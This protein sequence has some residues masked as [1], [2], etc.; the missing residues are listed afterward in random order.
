MKTLAA[1]TLM[2]LAA[3]SAAADVQ[4]L[5]HV[6]VGGGYITTLNVTSLVPDQADWIVI[7]FYKENGSRWTVPSNLGNFDRLDLW[8]G[9]LQTQVV[10]LS[11]QSGVIESGWAMLV[12]PGPVALAAAYSA[13]VDSAPV[14][15]AGVLPAQA[16]VLN[17]LPV[18]IDAGAGRDTGVALVN[19]STTGG[20]ATFELVDAD[21][22]TVDTRTVAVPAKGKF[23]GLLSG[24]ALFP[25]VTALEGFL[26][27]TA[28]Q[29][30]AAAALRTEGAL[31]SALP[32]VHDILPWRNSHTIYVNPLLGSDHFNTGTLLSPYKTIRK[33]QS[34]SDR[35]WTI[36]L[37]PGLYS[38]ASGESFPV[39][40]GFCVQLRGADTRSV[41]ILGGGTTEIFTENCAVAGEYKGMISG[42]TIINPA[43]HGIF[44]NTSISVNGCR[45]IH[46]GG[47]GIE[48]VDGMP[49]ISDTT[50]TGNAVG[51]HVALGADPDLG[52]GLNF[53]TGGNFMAGN[54]QCDLFFE[55]ESVI[56]IRFNSWDHA[57]PTRGTVCTGGVDIAATLLPFIDY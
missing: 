11:S 1:L 7:H 20:D 12:S 37:L 46:C 6:V 24:A 16:D 23:A 14:A 21:G 3:G 28:V 31:F 25:A 22:H 55:G 56:G 35:G 48:I 52:G 18:S 27:I 57:I 53:C 49:I 38:E 32:A 44:V 5:P 13:T 9:P 29:P 4:Y 54:E 33:A 15:T 50:V 34:A 39:E 51:V 40:L 47:T 2:L 17:I 26:K 42:A 30:L 36:Y 19:P 41:V 45:I 10:V 8:T 43:G